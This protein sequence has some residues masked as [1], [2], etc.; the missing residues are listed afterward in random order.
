MA[1]LRIEYGYAGKV[2]G[3][4]A[5]SATA[6][7]DDHLI[8]KARA[9]RI[10]QKNPGP[11]HIEIEETHFAPS[12]SSVYTG[13]IEYSFGFSSARIVGETRVSGA[14]SMQIFRDWPS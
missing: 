7:L 8:A 3:G 10:I 5:D 9:T 14:K 4:I 11:N 12:G 2:G 13:L 6:Y 1:Q